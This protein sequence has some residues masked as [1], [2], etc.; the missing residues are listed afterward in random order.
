MSLIKLPLLL[1]LG[2]LLISTH[3]AQTQCLSAVNPVGGSSNLLV[4][5]KNMLRIISFYHHHYGN[6][7]FEGDHL[8]D[9]NLIKS[10]GYNYIGTILGYGLTDKITLETELGYFINKTQQYSGIPEYT[11]R[12]NGLSNTVFSLKGSLLKNNEKRLFISSSAGAKI[13]LSREQQIRH[14]VVLP[15]ELQPTLGAFG[16]VFQL[17]AVKE[18]SASGTRY[19]LTERMEINDRNKQKYKQGNAVYSSLFISKHLMFP[20]LKGDWTAILQVRNELRGKDHISSGVKESSGGYQF[21]VSP[22]INH[23]FREKWNFS[24]ILD[25]PVYQNFNG[26][27]LAT[28]YG[29]SLNL[30]RDFK[31]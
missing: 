7:Y 16:A 12:G 24:A 10:G 13:P 28:K 8:S 26:T 3:P 29:L 9:Y 20:W 31:L 1:I 11:L 2:L 5:E 17:F 27:Q 14:G 19:F 22:Q 15:V 4:M 18:N 25:I 30:A 6:Q 23:Y 21:Y